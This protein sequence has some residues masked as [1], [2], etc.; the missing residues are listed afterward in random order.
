MC[1]SLKEVVLL[2][3]AFAACLTVQGS[4]VAQDQQGDVYIHWAYQRM[5]ADE[6]GTLTP[7]IVLHRIAPLDRATEEQSK[8]VVTSSRALTGSGIHS[9][10]RGQ[11]LVSGFRGKASFV[12]LGSGQVNR[13]VNGPAEFLLL[14]PTHDS[15]IFSMP[16]FTVISQYDFASKTTTP[17]VKGSMQRSTSF[18]THTHSRIALSPDGHQLAT[19]TFA[20]SEASA[21]LVHVFDIHI[22]DLQATPPAARPLKH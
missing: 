21:A 8:R 14:N 7:E 4:S 17:L 2:A 16:L 13:T 9:I 15:I 5:K 20:G 1:R 3:G 11:M 19:A 12:D 6:N 10:N 22:V 18:A